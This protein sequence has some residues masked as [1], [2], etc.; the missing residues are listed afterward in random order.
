MTGFADD[1]RR[2]GLVVETRSTEVFAGI[3][4][5]LQDSIQNGSVVTGSPGQPVDTG[6]LRAS[7][8]ST[9][10]TPTKAIVSTN[11]V[12]APSIEDGVSYAH[13]GTPMQL[14]S[15]VGGFHSVALSVA[16]F[17]RLVAAVAEGAG[18]AP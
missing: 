9:F 18:G 11:V 8:H 2:F 13:G 7:W 12:Y 3:V 17:D 15:E 5:A 6:N 14:R 4:S 1:I 10:E 16:G